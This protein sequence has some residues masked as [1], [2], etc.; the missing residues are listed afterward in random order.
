RRFGSEAPCAA[1]PAPGRGRDLGAKAGA[2]SG[3]R[4]ARGGAGA[5]S[6]G[7]REGPAPLVEAPGL[8]LAPA[9]EPQG[10]PPALS[11]LTDLAEDPAG[12]PHSGRGPVAAGA[13]G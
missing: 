12:I 5:G 10:H 11:D 13:A 3:A 6:A 8:D 9:R 2:P 7:A 1:G 4:A